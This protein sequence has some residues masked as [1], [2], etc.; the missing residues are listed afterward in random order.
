MPN[1]VTMG[2][3]CPLPPP[4][5]LLFQG[6][7]GDLWPRVGANAQPLSHIRVHFKLQIIPSHHELIGNTRGMIIWRSVFYGEVRILNPSKAIW[8]SNKILTQPGGA[9]WWPLIGSHGSLWLATP[10]QT[11]QPEFN[12]SPIQRCHMPR[13]DWFDANHALHI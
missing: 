2:W 13:P 3:S 10:K 9:M 8:P 12:K 1:S 5:L 6:H 11:I 7:V 4:P